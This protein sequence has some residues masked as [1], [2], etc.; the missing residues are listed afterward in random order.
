VILEKVYDHSLVLYPHGVF[1]YNYSVSRDTRLSEIKVS[2]LRVE[3]PLE[4]W[5]ARLI[6]QLQPPNPGLR[7]ID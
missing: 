3:L 7:F 1:L 6:P 4:I 5:I 2:L